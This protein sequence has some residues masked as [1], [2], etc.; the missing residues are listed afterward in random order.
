MS[1]CG[2]LE[3]AVWLL[4]EIRASKNCIPRVLPVG[5][6]IVSNNLVETAVSWLRDDGAATNTHA[7][8]RQEQWMLRSNERTTFDEIQIDPRLL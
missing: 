6:E 4:D 8:H 5:V 3:G 2:I 7:Q 1:G